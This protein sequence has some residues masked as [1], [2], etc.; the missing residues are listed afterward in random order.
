MDLCV[1]S[2][3]SFKT[4]PREIVYLLALLEVAV[5][6]SW[7]TGWLSPERRRAPCGRGRRRR[8]GPT[9]RHKVSRLQRS[10][11]SE[12]RCEA[13]GADTVLLTPPWE[14]PYAQ[15]ALLKASVGDMR[16]AVRAVVVAEV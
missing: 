6:A 7:R 2:I 8:P 15:E 13:A 14:G 1:K 12:R 16:A 3:L 4:M 9:Q 10:P 5:P 11:S